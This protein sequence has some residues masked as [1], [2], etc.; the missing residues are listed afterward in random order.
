MKDFVLFMHDDSTDAGLANDADAWARYLK[1]LRSTGHFGGGSVIGAGRCHS[2]SGNVP[3]VTA[4]LTGYLRVQAESLDEAAAFL[5]GNPVYEA[6]G[7]VEIR[8]LPNT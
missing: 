1:Q 2:R 3:P 8:E 6:G 4:Q 7:T 5:A